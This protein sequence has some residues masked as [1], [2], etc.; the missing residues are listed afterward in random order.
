MNEE[1]YEREL[2]GNK[3]NVEKNNIIVEKWNMRINKKSSKITKN[4]E[5]I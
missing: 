1:E 3:I 4:M 2:W 5:W